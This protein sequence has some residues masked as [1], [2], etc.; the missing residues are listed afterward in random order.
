MVQESVLLLG[1]PVHVPHPPDMCSR[2]CPPVEEPAVGEVSELVVLRTTAVGCPTEDPAF[3]NSVRSPETRL[4][5]TPGLVPSPEGLFSFAWVTPPSPSRLS[6]H[7]K[8]T[9][10]PAFTFQQQRVPCLSSLPDCVFH[11]F[12]N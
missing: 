12:L 7:L 5:R 8:E 11:L 3:Q 9:F 10:L 2:A 6:S 1:S 4:C